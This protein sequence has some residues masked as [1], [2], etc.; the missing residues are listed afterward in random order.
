VQAVLAI[1]GLTLREASRRRLVLVGLLLGGAFVALYGTAL[2]LVLRNAPCGPAARPCTTPFQLAQYRAAVNILT[3]AGL[4]VAN[5]LTLATAVL[6]PVDTLS[7]EISSGVAQTLASKPIHRSEIVLGK[8]FAYFLMV[9][10]FLAMTSGGIL[11]TVWVVTRNV[12]GGSGFIVAGTPQALPIMLLASTVMLT[13]SIAG[14]SRLSTVTNGM[15]AF[16]VFGLG[17]LGGWLE[18][19]GEFVVQTPLARQAIRDIGTVVSLLTPSDALWRLA[20]SHMIPPLARDLPITPFSSL[21]PP[22]MA[23][24]FWGLGYTAVT[25][26][27]ALRWFARRPL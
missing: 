26:G 9:L 14:G 18:Q 7:G 11:G 23:M 25:L 19:V 15:V 27:S 24:V 16:G 21:Y 13:V 8:W 3:L 10:A 17:L 22:S 4:Y 5:L 2:W 20:A 12:T 6:L 1:T